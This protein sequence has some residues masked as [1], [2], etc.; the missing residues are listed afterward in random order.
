MKL[1]FLMM[2][3]FLLEVAVGWRSNSYKKSHGKL[4]C[5]DQPLEWDPSLSK[6]AKITCDKIKKEELPCDEAEETKGVVCKEIPEDVLEN[7]KNKNWYI[8]TLAPLSTTI[9]ED[10]R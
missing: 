9:A 3:V 7:K 2:S 1:L 4:T 10:V 5:Y 8:K 6:L